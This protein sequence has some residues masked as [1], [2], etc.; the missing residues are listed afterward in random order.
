[1]APRL[2][3]EAAQLR[4]NFDRFCEELYEL[5]DRRECDI[6]FDHG[7]TMAE[8]DCEMMKVSYAE[9]ASKAFW[10]PYVNDAKLDE[11]LE[12]HEEMIKDIEQSSERG[13]TQT[14]EDAYLVSL[15]YS[16]FLWFCVWRSTVYNQVF[17][18]PEGCPR[19]ELIL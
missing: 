12:D 10:K 6:E 15:Q 5:V 7:K 1:M 2:I 9:S 17:D 8:S 3:N 18:E 14:V 4:S 19:F 11:A 16:D 13:P